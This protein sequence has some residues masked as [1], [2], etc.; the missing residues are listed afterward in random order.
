MKKPVILRKR[1]IP[2]ET[3]DI[4]GDELFSRDEDVII[5]KWNVIR[6][7]ADIAKGVSFAFIKEGYK[8]SRFY[9]RDGSFVYWYCDIIDVEYKSDIDE[10]TF[11]DLL[12]DV[13][14]FPDGSVRILDVDEIADCVESKLITQEQLCSS[15]RKL[16]KLLKMIYQGN[17]P[18]EV[19]RNEELWKV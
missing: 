6:P 18:P 1:F 9:S 15:L 14:I 7:R 10:Y 16:D 4:S 19:C 11:V 13:K 5:T 12:V 8:I 2:F 17:F 3:V